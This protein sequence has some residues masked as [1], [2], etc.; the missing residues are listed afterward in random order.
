MTNLEHFIISLQRH[1]A[2]AESEK[3]LVYGEESYVLQE[4][5]LFST[6]FCGGVGGDLSKHRSSCFGRCDFSN[7]AVVELAFFA[8]I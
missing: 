7:S 5:L 8:C 6:D 3:P 1:E 2:Q 4:E